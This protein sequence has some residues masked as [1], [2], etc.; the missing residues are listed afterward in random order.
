MI[1][2]KITQGGKGAVKM[3]LGGARTA[4][5]ESVAEGVVRPRGAETGSGRN[6]SLGGVLGQE[7]FKCLGGGRGGLG[8]TDRRWLGKGKRSFPKP[9]EACCG[10]G[11]GPEMS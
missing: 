2:K 3:W 5:L 4:R 7:N 10:M 1:G 8:L 6:T 11:G 9:K